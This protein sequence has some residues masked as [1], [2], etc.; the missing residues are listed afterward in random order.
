MKIGL[1]GNYHFF[2]LFFFLSTLSN[3][4]NYQTPGPNFIL[5]KS[6]AYYY[7]I[8]VHVTTRKEREIFFFLLS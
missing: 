3:L 5:I 6:N 8:H 2:F 1:G 4:F 7:I